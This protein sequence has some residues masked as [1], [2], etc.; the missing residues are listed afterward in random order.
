MSKFKNSLKGNLI[1][2][3]KSFVPNLSVTPTHICFKNYDEGK[4]YKESIQILNQDLVISERFVYN[5]SAFAV[6][7]SDFYFQKT[8]HL[9]IKF[10]NTNEIKLSI[11]GSSKTKIDSGEDFMLEVEFRPMSSFKEESIDRR[12]E[13]CLNIVNSTTKFIIPVLVL[14]PN[15]IINFPTEIFLPDTAV[16][17]PAYSNIFVLNY[18]NQNQRFSFEFRNDIRIVPE[19]KCIGLKACDGASY[20]IEYIPK[21]VGSFLDK[22]QVHFA[23]GKKALIIIKCTVVPVNIFIGMHLL[24]LPCS[25]SVVI[26]CSYLDEENVTFSPT[27]VGMTDSRELHIVNNSEEASYFEWISFEQLQSKRKDRTDTNHFPTNYLQVTP[28][29]SKNIDLP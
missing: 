2:K 13:I 20:L 3:T 7:T 16:N 22:I 21:V 5:Q 26:Y 18:S 25:I 14:S 29:V 19:C 27:F 8:Y 10:D 12:Y 4:F 11:V 1:K 9:A 24:R 17:T 6:Y 28:M 15:P 23:N